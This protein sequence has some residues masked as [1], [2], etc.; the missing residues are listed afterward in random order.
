M[1]IDGSVVAVTGGGSGIGAALARRFA[2]EGAAAVEVIDLR[3]DA[4]T[5]VAEEIGPGAHASAVDV[6]DEAAVTHLVAGILDRHGR[7]DLFCSNAGLATATGLEGGPEANA[8]WQRAWEVHVMAH[9]YAARAVLPA[10]IAAG[11]GY[12]LN[13]ASAAGLLSSPGDAPYAVTKHA[14]VAFAEWLAFQHAHLGIR[15]SVLCP[16]GVD[17]PLLMTGVYADAPAAMAVLSSG[18]LI[19]VEQVADSVMR[20]VS[21]ESFLILPHAQVGKFWAGKAADIDSWLA[22]M[23]R[24]AIKTGTAST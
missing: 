18:E 4:A 6:T 21:N 7:I 10:M 8:I 12:L 11:S 2:A 9:V 13:T 1:R 20:A 23:S 17:T 22:G 3:L 15:V 24:L 14:A 5:A 16:L 19:T